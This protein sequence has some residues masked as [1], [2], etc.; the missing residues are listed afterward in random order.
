MNGIAN[1]DM[2]QAAPRAR[3]HAIGDA[4]VTGPLTRDEKRLI[5]LAVYEPW[6][7]DLQRCLVAAC[8]ARGFPLSS[9][10]DTCGYLADWLG[11]RA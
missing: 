5:E 7:D 3:R 4:T 2:I 10:Y 1:A 9:Y 11:T 6:T 8:L